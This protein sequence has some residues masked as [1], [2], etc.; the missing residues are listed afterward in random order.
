MKGV[1][2]LCGFSVPP[3][4][5]SEICSLCEEQL[6]PKEKQ[7]TELTLLHD[8]MV[9]C[10]IDVERIVFKDG[11]WRAQGHVIYEGDILH[12]MRGVAEEWLEKEGW[13]PDQ[14]CWHGYT[15]DV[16]EC[17]KMSYSLPEALRY[18]HQQKETTND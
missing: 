13:I 7:P 5:D 12:I 10:G 2:D 9:E 8:A 15:E 1:C 11:F 16:H 3:N 6:F 4:S 17:S 14:N 18:A